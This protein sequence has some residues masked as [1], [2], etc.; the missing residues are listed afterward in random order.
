[1]FTCLLDHFMMC[2]ENKEKHVPFSQFSQQSCGK[3]DI[4]KLLVKCLSKNA[5]FFPWQNL[6]SLAGSPLQQTRSEELRLA[7]NVRFQEHHPLML[8]GT[9]TGDKSAVVRSIRLQPKTTIQ[10]FTFLTLK[11]QMLV[12]ISAKLRTT[13]EVT[14]VFA[15]LS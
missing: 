6:L 14:L 4:S 10:A 13:Q 7:W 5:P 8:P 11:L 1:M 2:A 15:L 12:N 3:A 9:K